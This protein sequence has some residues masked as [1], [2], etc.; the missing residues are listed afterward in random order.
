M[1]SI[2]LNLDLETASA[3]YILIDT[4]INSLSAEKVAVETLIRGFKNP[5]PNTLSLEQ[6]R[7]LDS[8][9]TEL[10]SAA[11]TIG[12]DVA[13]IIS[14]FDDEQTEFKPFT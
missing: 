3:L 11:K 8:N 5:D 7:E 4:S 12:T 13:E 10:I 9:L 1:Q 6:L 14:M 2:P